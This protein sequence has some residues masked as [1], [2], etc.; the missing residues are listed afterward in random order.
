MT[1]CRQIT[2]T[3][4][5]LPCDQLPYPPE[6][7]RISRIRQRDKTDLPLLTLPYKYFLPWHSS[8]T[9]SFY[10]LQT[11]LSGG[12][13]VGELNNSNKDLPQHFFKSSIFSFFKR[14][15]LSTSSSAR[16]ILSHLLFLL[17]YLYLLQLYLLIIFFLSS[18]FFC[19]SNLQTFRNWPRKS[20]FLL[21]NPNFNVSGRW[22]TRILPIW[23]MR[24][25]IGSPLEL[26][27]S[28]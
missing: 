16:S 18:P 11:H 8:S 7:L 6:H 3:F 13:I 23:S 27:I 24:K 22:V 2:C 12:G 10:I 19:S 21:N 26:R 1:A 20:W 15:W 4:P 5:W 14:T 28:P 9:L 17:P 25:Q